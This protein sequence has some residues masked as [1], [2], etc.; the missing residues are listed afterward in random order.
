MAKKLQRRAPAPRKS[1]APKAAAE[2]NS[3][4]GLFRAG[5]RVTPR[6][7]T[8]F[9]NQLAVLL[10]AGIPVTRSL[11][12][13]EGQ[14]PPGGMRLATKELVEDVEGGTPLSEA[15]G[16]HPRIFN[17][18]YTNM[19]RAG[20]AGGIQEEILNR[21]AFFME[22]TE[23]IKSKVKGAMAYPIAVLGVAV[24]VLGFAFVFVIPKF[25][26]VFT[27]L[28]PGGEAEMHWTTRLVIQTGEH[29]QAW[30]W[31]YLLL[32]M[33]IY[34]LHLLMLSRVGGYKAAWD[35][36]MLRL[37]LLGG[38]VRRSLVARFTR[39][40]GTLIQSG[41]P[42]L[43]ALEIVEASQGNVHM[44]TA[45]QRVHA[46][47]REGGGIAIPM[48]ESGMFDDIVVNMVDVGEQTGELDRMLTKIADR[49]ETEV[50][51][52]VETVFKFIEPLLLVIMAVIVGFIVYAL[53]SPLLTMMSTLSAG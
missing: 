27:Q 41:V 12:V 22:R 18:L 3:S 21:L 19:V 51:R 34:C 48:G 47:I 52:T 35:R 43:E 45:V 31:V 4:P 15:M 40:F 5:K 42:H 38:L 11:R 28:L 46:S 7:L 16:K 23:Q 32:I 13:L 29:M 30:W 33:G 17:N 2:K 6:I 50:D 8:E 36:L 10:D 49:Y 24:L 44:S 39:T 9:T 53:F 14:M 25:K 20:E 1:A 37:P 26:E